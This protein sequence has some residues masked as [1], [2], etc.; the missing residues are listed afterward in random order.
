MAGPR[1][2]LADV[3]CGSEVAVDQVP[4]GVEGERGRVV[5]HPALQAQWA[6]TGLDEHRR[7]G[8]PEG[9]KAD[10]GQASALGGGDE[11]APAQA[12]L[13]GRAA[14]ATRKTNASSTALSGR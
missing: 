4:V 5:A 3:E 2:L 12:A 6:Q 1:Q 7:A 11:H 13:I 8:V 10:T 9:V 14:V